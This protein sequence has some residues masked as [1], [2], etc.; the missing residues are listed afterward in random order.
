MG[1]FT[2]QEKGG[3]HDKN[4]SGKLSLTPFV[5]ISVEIPNRLEILIENIIPLQ[6]F[7]S[8][9]PRTVF[10]RTSRLQGTMFSAVKDNEN[11]S[12]IL[13]PRKLKC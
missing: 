9:Q 11:I 2:Q 4:F 1:K 6:S 3:E 12:S 5:Y 8:S 13:F 7:L 10:L